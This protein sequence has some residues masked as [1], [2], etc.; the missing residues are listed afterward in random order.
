[1]DE[2]Y[3]QR[4]REIYIKGDSAGLFRHILSLE[5]DMELDRALALLEKCVSEKR[6]SWIR[7]KLIEVN[8]SGNPVERAYELF[9]EMYL[10]ASTPGDGEIIEKTPGRI[11]M[12]WWNR[13]PTLSACNELGLDTRMICKKVYHTPVQDF[14]TAINPRLRF[15]RNYEHIRP[16][17]AYCEE[18]ITLL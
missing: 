12:R 2:K 5:K 14:L 9:Y 7:K 18:S 3:Y 11:V 1:M 8:L 15:D 16:Y 6:L 13:C 17:T 4:I 10:G